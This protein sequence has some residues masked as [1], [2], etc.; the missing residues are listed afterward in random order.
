M[1]FFAN[2]EKKSNLL[3]IIKDNRSIQSIIEKIII[4]E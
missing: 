4:L 3:K 1:L 2:F